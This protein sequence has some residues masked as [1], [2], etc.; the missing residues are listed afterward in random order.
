M[1]RASEKCT[2]LRC[3]CTKITSSVATLPDVPAL[4]LTPP[5]TRIANGLARFRE[6]V[7][8]PLPQDVE[9]PLQL[10]EPRFP[11]AETQPLPSDVGPPHRHAVGVHLVPHPHV[12]AVEE[13]LAQPDVVRPLRQL[14]AHGGEQALDL[15]RPDA[16]AHAAGA[17]APLHVVQLR[18]APLGAHRVAGEHLVPD[19]PARRIHQA[20]RRRVRGQQHDQARAARHAA[21]RRGGDPLEVQLRAGVRAGGGRQQAGQAYAGG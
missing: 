7:T 21:A 15:P 18:L 17:S 14:A 16:P 13:L 4:R 1:S 11:E 8:V 20:Q 10:L 2:S 19:Q 5:C 12:A 6:P 9:R 3:L